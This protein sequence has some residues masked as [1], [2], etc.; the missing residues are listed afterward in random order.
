MRAQNDERF[1][2]LAIEK[3]RE[4][5][6][7]GQSPFGVCLARSGRVVVTAHNRVWE[8]S[9][10]TAHAEILAIREAC[11]RLNTVDLSGCTLYSTTEPC[12]MCFGAIHWARID[13][14]VYG[15]TISD[16]KKAGFNE[17]SLSNEQMKRLGGSAVEVERGVLRQECQALFKEWS[18]LGNPP[19]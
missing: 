13:R 2:L 3:A 19:Y 9:D 5:L 6:Q 8:T 7:K 17:L 11:A 18:R 16:G 14:I 10:I 12:P 15:A 1:M 4:G